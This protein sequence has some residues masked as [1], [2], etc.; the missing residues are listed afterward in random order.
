MQRFTELFYELGSTTKTGEKLAALEK[1]FASADPRDAAWAL[2]FLTGQKIK[3]SVSGSLLR[4]WVSEMSGNPLWLVEE[5]YNVVGDLAETLALLL[6]DTGSISDMPLHQAAEERVLPLPK[7][8][9]EQ[10][11]ALVE[12]TWTEFSAP[13]RL[14]WHKLI[15]GEFRVGVSSTLVVRALSGLARVAPAVMAHR[16]MGQWKPTPE[17]YQSFMQGTADAM[18]PH[19]PYPFFL[20]YPLEPATVAA[21]TGLAGDHPELGAVDKWQIE[22]KWDGIRAQLIH[23]QEQIAVWSR[24]ED[25]VTE[26]FPE[27]TLAARRL[28]DGTVLDGEIL[29]WRDGK[30][31][32]FGSLQARLGRKDVHAKILLDVPV[33]FMAYDI[34]EHNGVDVREKGTGERRALLEAVVPLMSQAVSPVLMLS[35]VVS[36]ATWN[37][38]LALQSTARDRGTEGFMLKRK[39]AAYGVRRITGDWWK[40]KIAPFELDAVLLYAQGGHGRRAGLYTDYTFGVWD[41]D[42]LVPIA[43]AYSGLTDAEIRQVDNF[44]RRNTLER[45]GPVRV[46]KP[47]LVFQLAFEGVQA[48]TRHKAGV[49]V[50]FPRMARWRQDKKAAEADKLETLKKLI[51]VAAENNATK[52]TTTEKDELDPKLDPGPRTP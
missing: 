10:R 17:T 21:M 27:I 20:A 24:G 18:D 14:V 34:L 49:A 42:K 6:R 4:Q 37:D 3:R 46:V 44:V 1:Y 41:G 19:Q 40:W 52:P 23:R 38:L 16:V 36:A 25:V 43:K 35:P 32:P 5:S 45:F 48:S 7:M 33:V 22:W 12:K 50:R 28:P 39:D 15:T 47:E 13:Q 11:R 29:A 2:F 26:R 9:D 31:M 51:P 8:T 30:V